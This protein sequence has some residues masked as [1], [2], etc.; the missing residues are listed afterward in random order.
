[1]RGDPLNYTFKVRW[2]KFN[3]GYVRLTIN[4]GPNGLPEDNLDMGYI[5]NNHGNWSVDYSFSDNNP[6]PTTYYIQARILSEP[7]GTTIWSSNF[8]E[9]PIEYK[10]FKI[11]QLQMVNNNLWSSYTS[12][13]TNYNGIQKRNEAFGDA[14]THFKVI[15][16]ISNLTSQII[17]NSSDLFR[18]TVLNAGGNLN[19][20]DYGLD[21]D[22]SIVCGIDDADYTYI[23]Q[24]VYGFAYHRGLRDNKPV[25]SRTYTLYKR[26]RESG[27][28]DEKKVVIGVGVTIHE[29]GHARGI[30][31][32]E[33]SPIPPHSDDD[34]R[35][36]CIMWPG[37]FPPTPNPPE[38][39]ANLYSPYFC[40][41]H[42]EFIQNITW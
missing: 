41:G 12:G 4:P 2:N 17:E 8:L 1:M 20:S 24:G 18:W 28:S 5:N 40:R 19:A 32:D 38:E 13:N 7:G 16:T 31:G 3:S 15:N 27:Y 22:V 39:R 10:N 37:S 21:Q 9:L 42:R 36:N 33:F 11:I 25:P 35:K 14:L 6:S 30:R 34:I 26:I 23:P 29:L